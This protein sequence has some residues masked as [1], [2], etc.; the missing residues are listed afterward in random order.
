MTAVAAVVLGAAVERSARTAFAVVGLLLIAALASQVARLPATLVFAGAVVLSSALV[1]L[2]NRFHAGRFSANAGLTIAYAFWG[3]LVLVLWRSSTTTQTT[4]P[5]RPFVVLLAFALLSIGW[6]AP[7]I[8]AV[9]NILVLFVFIVSVLA[10][11]QVALAE[12]D[13]GHFAA[14]VFGLGS[15]I[16]LTLYAGSLAIGGVGAGSVVGNRSFALFA[17]LVVAWGASGWRYG[18]KFGRIL[19]LLGSLLILLS[20]S[21][22]AFAAALVIVCLTWFNSRSVA[23]WSRLITTVGGAA[24][25]AYLAVQ[26]V[27]PLHDRIYTG[28]VRSVGGGIAINLAGRSKIWATTWHSYLTS[29]IFGHG[30]GTADSLISRTYGS[31][32]GHPHNDYLRLL[33]DYGLVGM[34]LWA[35]GY[36]WLLRRTWQSWQRPRNAAIPGADRLDVE[37]RVHAAA[38]LSLI[39]VALAMITDNVIVYMFVM[40]PLGVLIGLSLGLSS[41][42][43]AR[44]SPPDGLRSG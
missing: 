11:S 42:R 23:G 1:D 33:H 12:S 37:L 15:I 38:F 7:S 43:L 14:K 3:V 17:L 4:K 30:S 26:H 18:A 2:P 9:Q 10:G 35:L 32:A 5:L 20:L 22:T 31:E 16:A 8:T 13:T 44:V 19:A 41:R 28:D 6:G 25:V 29:P 24:A 36:A 21:R 40:A 27:R 39:G 34:S